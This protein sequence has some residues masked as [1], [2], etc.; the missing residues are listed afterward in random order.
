MKVRGTPAVPVGGARVLA[1][2]TRQEI[3]DVL[4]SAGPCTVARLAGLL[5]RT[6]DG[7]YFH[8]RA[9]LRAG[10]VR[11]VSADPSAGR[12]GAVYGLP[13]G[14]V[15]LDYSDAPRADLA[16][17]V[18]L[19]I[20]LSV[21]E[22]ERE[23]LAGRPVGM[24]PRRRLWGGRVVGWLSPPELARANA[25]VKELNSLFRAGRPGK[26]R[27]PMSLGFLLAPSGRGERVRNKKAGGA[28][29]PKERT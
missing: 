16:R 17:V 26:G 13:P 24:G 8:L 20:N 11:E 9:L 1:S 21:R 25:L 2:A 27:V 29:A 5:G 28:H 19:A 22:F 4:A 18:R 3:V 12:A 15:R 14:G 6:A 10:L 23:C 7:L